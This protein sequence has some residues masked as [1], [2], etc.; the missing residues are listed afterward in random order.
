MGFTVWAVRYTVAAACLLSVPSAEYIGRMNE[1]I[2]W[3]IPFANPLEKFGREFFTAVPPRPGVYR[4]IAESGLILYI[5]KAKHLRNRL[6]SYRRAHPDRDSR[7]VIRMLHLVHS[8]EWEECATELDALLRENELLRTLQP[9]FNIQN[10]YPETYYLIGV[11][12]DLRRRR[13]IRFRLT[14]EQSERESEKLFGAYKGRG[15]TRDAYAALLRL[16]WAALSR[17][18]TSKDRFDF[19]P[20]LIRY[21]SPREYE[22]SLE[23]CS[24]KETRAWLKSVHSFLNGNSSQLLRRLTASLLD[25]PRIPPYLYYRIQDDIEAMKEFYE[26]GSRRNRRL[27][28]TLGVTEALIPQDELDDLLAKVA[29]KKS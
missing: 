2:S 20:Q 11:A 26:Y 6:N 27:R 15:R 19:P 1:S 21:R 25:N 7:K 9:P 23:H 29:M 8:I 18:Q 24:S 13:A 17:A 4:M 3:L 14:T 28:K 12:A 22:I 16:F 5:G 10:T